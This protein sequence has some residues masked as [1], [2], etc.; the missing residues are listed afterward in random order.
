MSSVSK[1]QLVRY[2]KG[3]Y[4]FE[5][6]TKKG[7]VQLFLEGKLGWDKVLA[8]DA[9][10]TN[11]KKGDIARKSELISVFGSDDIN[12]CAE[13][14][15]RQGNAQISASE[16]KEDTQKHKRAVLSYLNKSY[17]DQ[18]GLPH[19]VTRLE[20]ALEESKTRIDPTVSVN[21][22]AE[23]FIKKMMGK[24]VFKKGGE[25][26][27][28]SVPKEYAK[29]CSAVVHRFSPSL[30]KEIRSETGT[31]WKICLNLPDFDSFVAEMNRFTTGNFT[32]ERTTE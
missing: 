6:I 3:K 12:K 20:I 17:T 23:E 24:L 26:Y 16:R 5:I 4:S 19:P 27:T 31:I 29:K 21:K 18:A 14:M 22:I 1:D 2:K 15:V 32:L 8:V 13:F 11:S 28:L 10:F 7:S 30:H 9:I 25:D